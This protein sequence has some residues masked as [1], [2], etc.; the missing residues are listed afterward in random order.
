M[1]P[2]EHLKTFIEK[3]YDVYQD[4]A[5]DLQIPTKESQRDSSVG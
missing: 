4:M 5:K 1:N 3:R 2:L